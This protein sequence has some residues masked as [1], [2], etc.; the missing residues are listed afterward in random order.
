MSLHKPV[1]AALTSYPFASASG[2]SPKD[3]NLPQKPALF[4]LPA[5]AGRSSGRS[6]GRRLPTETLLRIS[7]PLTTQILAAGRVQITEVL[8]SHLG[9]WRQAVFLACMVSLFSSVA[10]YMPYLGPKPV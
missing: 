7:G 1:K 10:P 4:R 9:N 5:G 8:G 6:P 3:R 2:R